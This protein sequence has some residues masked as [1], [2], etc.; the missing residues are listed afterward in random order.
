MLT[1]ITPVPGNSCY[2]DFL[3]PKY[4]M[5]YRSVCI[6]CLYMT[7]PLEIQFQKLFLI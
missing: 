7:L 1:G 2:L 4:G 3:V 6:F 5:G